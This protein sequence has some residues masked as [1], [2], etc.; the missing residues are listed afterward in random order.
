MPGRGTGI[1]SVMACS[2]GRLVVVFAGLPAGAPAALMAVAG[3]LRLAAQRLELLPW[4]E[5]V[6]VEGEPLGALA[7]GALDGYNHLVAEGQDVHNLALALGSD[8]LFI[9]LGELLAGFHVILV[10]V[11]QAAAQATAHAGDFGRRER[12]ALLLG[13]L[14]GDGGEVGQELGAAASFKAAGPHA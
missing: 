7:F 11:D 10:F 2:V 9:A 4:L 12:D 5:L 1:S 6:T 3:C 14:D 8:D 13:H